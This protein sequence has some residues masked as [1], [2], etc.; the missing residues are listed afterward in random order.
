LDGNFVFGFVVFAPPL[1]PRR[2]E[3]ATRLVNVGNDV[4]SR[5]TFDWSQR[6]VT[7]KQSQLLVQSLQSIVTGMQML[8][9]GHAAAAAAAATRLFSSMNVTILIFC[10]CCSLIP[11]WH[12][13]RIR[14]TASIQWRQSQRKW[15]LF[16][17]AG[18]CGGD[19]PCGFEIMSFST[20]KM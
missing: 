9:N 18:G 3:V 14:A 13:F 10:C 6:H 11:R 2:K 17:G 12:V 16:D 1:P 8:Q 19:D 15:N 7:S 20:K 5:S 4:I